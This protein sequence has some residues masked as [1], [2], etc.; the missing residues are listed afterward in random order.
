MK[1]L[2]QYQIH[3]FCVW[4]GRLGEVEV[5][6]LKV[7]SYYYKDGIIFSD[8]QAYLTKTLQDPIESKSLKDIKYE[9]FKFVRK[10]R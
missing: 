1:Y 4:I 10:I 6:Y 2:S 9:N 7:W 3:F 8:A 5:D